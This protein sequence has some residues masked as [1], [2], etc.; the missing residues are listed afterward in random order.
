M[1]IPVSRPSITDLEKKYVNDA[2][3][4]EWIS[5]QGP[6]VKKFEESWAK[7]NEMEYGIAC[8][9]GTTAIQLAIESLNL[10]EDA[11]VIV[12]EFTMIATAWAVSQAGAKPVFVD[13]G[14]DLNIDVNKIEAAITPRTKAIVPVHIYGRQCNME[15]INRIAYEYNLYVIEDSAEAHGIKPTGDI[16]CFSLFANKIINSGEGGICLTNNKHLAEQIA[17]LRAMSFN[18]NHT[19]LHP[20]EGHNFRMTALQAAFALGQVERIDDILKK[21]KQI[22]EWYDEGLNPF[23]NISPRRDVLWMYDILVEDREE[24]MSF[25]REKGIETRRFFQPMSA[26]PMYKN[27]IELRASWFASRGLYLPT[28]YDLTKEEVDYIC[29]SIKEFYK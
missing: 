21:R 14:D 6:Y 8:S 19:F 10:S 26:Q 1:K 3:D 28:F 29:E 11:E 25:L 23:I 15:D 9:S 27:D 16:A 24:L 13:C 4:T 2:L 22:E 18:K 12:P 17:H 5:S 20:K 7:W